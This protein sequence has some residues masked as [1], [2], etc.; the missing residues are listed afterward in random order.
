[1]RP[2]TRTVTIPL[3]E[4]DQ[5][6]KSAARPEAEEVECLAC[7]GLGHTYDGRCPVCDG[8]GLATVHA[9]RA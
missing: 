4:Y 2:A 3:A 7:S 8:R 9:E 1:M 5:L 6:R